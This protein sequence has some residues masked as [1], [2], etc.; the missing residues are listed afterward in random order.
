MR[1][2]PIAVVAVVLAAPL[3]ACGQN[4]TDP[5]DPAAGNLIPNGSFEQNGQGTLATWQVPNPSLASLSPE[6]APDG[7][8]WSLHLQA[9]SAPSS[10]QVRVPVTGLQ[11]GDTVHL[12]AY[13]RAPDARGGG[14]VGLEVISSD[15]RLRQESFDSSVDTDWT[16]V[17][18]TETLSID[19]GDSVWVVLS[20]PPT[21]LAA[22]AGLFDLVVLE[23]LAR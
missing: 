20:S 8:K 23:R 11:R 13:V 9:D 4:T 16:R 15:G 14:L 12:S 17:A 10:G 22:R 2:L 1:W 7:G 21:Q 5:S 6:A 19:P 3:S 18:V